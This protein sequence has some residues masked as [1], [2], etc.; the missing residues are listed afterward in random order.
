MS[1]TIAPQ[2]TERTKSAMGR[3]THPAIAAT[4]ALVEALTAIHD[5][6]ERRKH[7]ARAL[8]EIARAEHAEAQRL[9]DVVRP[10]ILTGY[11]AAESLCD[12]RR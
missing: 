7:T 3:P 5:V 10:E 6:C 1:A 9:C 2:P 11:R 8:M 4:E 12:A